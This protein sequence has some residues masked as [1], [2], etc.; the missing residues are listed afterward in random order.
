MVVVLLGIRRIFPA[1]KGDALRLRVPLM[2]A[3]I[4]ITAQQNNGEVFRVSGLPCNILMA[5]L[6][7]FRAV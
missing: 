2:R 1:A 3:V 7:P 4:I 5:S 6:P